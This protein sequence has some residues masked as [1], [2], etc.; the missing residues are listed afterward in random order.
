MFVIRLHNYIALMNM[1]FDENIFFCFH[2]VP[3]KETG[4]LRMYFEPG[5]LAIFLLFVERISS[6]ITSTYLYSIHITDQSELYVVTHGE[7]QDVKYVTGHYQNNGTEERHIDF[8]KTRTDVKMMFT[9]DIIYMSQCTYH[10]KPTIEVYS[11][12]EFN[13]Q[14]HIGSNNLGRVQ[15]TTFYDIDTNF[16]TCL[17]SI[18]QCQYIINCNHKNVQHLEFSFLN[19]YECFKTFFHADFTNNNITYLRN[20][21]GFLVHAKNL[22]KLTLFF[23]PIK[24][25]ASDA[26]ANILSLR[27]LFLTY[28]YT[29][30]LNETILPV[31]LYHNRKMVFI[32][33]TNPSLYYR[34]YLWQVCDSE[35]YDAVFNNTFKRYQFL[36][37]NNVLRDSSNK[38]SAPRSDKLVAARSSATDGDDDKGSVW[39]L[40]KFPLVL[41]GIIV[42]VLV[43]WRVYR[44]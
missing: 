37:A 27:F 25:I 32:N 20:K 19:T 11:I 8:L 1:L 24:L 39:G 22:V 5:I 34:C 12:P 36:D 18:E 33:C 43:V 41:G 16:E 21:N 29:E 4:N 2:L 3:V 44:K 35:Q 28:N 6:M 31:I 38:S 26:F 14:Y 30:Y 15:K 40:I 7:P 23:N 9:N 42:V 17:K 13:R 10:S